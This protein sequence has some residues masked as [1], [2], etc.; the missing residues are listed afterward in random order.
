MIDPSLGKYRREIADGESRRLVDVG[1]FE[2]IVEELDDVCDS[3]ACTGESIRLRKRAKQ[4]VI[5]I[6]K[7]IDNRWDL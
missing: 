7:E 3:M 1:R 2:E 6:K 4:L 5:D